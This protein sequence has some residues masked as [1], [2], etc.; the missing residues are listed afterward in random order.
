[1]NFTQALEEMKAG[2]KVKLP[3]WG[4]C[5][6][7]DE[8]KQTVMMQCRAKDSDEGQGDLLDIRETQRVEYTLLNMQRDD[9]VLANRENCPALG[10]ETMFGFDDALRYIKRGLRVSRKHWQ[11]ICKDGRYVEKVIA[12][13]MDE[14]Y[15]EKI[16]MFKADEM[17]LLDWQPTPD[18]LFAN[19]WC[20]ADDLIPT[21]R[22]RK[23]MTVKL[24]EAG[25]EMEIHEIERIPIEIN[26]ETLYVL[27]MYMRISY[28]GRMGLDSIMFRGKKIPVYETPGCMVTVH[29]LTKDESNEI[30]REL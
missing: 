20:F 11:T 4:G 10:G 18:D 7:W 19:D 2:A 26:G 1:M 27:K 12:G 8:E 28:T 13:T 3:A 5:W 9:W 17:P 6:Y 16:G 23:P 22:R 24:V 25:E 21:I 29:A 15:E 14:I 30:L